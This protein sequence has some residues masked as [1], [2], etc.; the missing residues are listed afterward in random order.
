MMISDGFAGSVADM[1][2]QALAA[3]RQRRANGNMARG[4]GIMY[5]L[6]GGLH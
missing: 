1:D 6:L 3:V 5:N 2:T 4:G